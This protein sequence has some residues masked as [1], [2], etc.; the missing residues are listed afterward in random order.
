LFCYFRYSFLFP[1]DGQ[2]ES[3]KGFKFFLKKE[4]G[5]LTGRMRYERPVE[6]LSIR[7]SASIVI[8]LL[9]DAIDDL[10]VPASSF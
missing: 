3:G 2:L 8:A 7:I 6:G 10:S 1:F 4:N 5:R 9:I